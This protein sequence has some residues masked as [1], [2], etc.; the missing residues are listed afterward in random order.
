MDSDG[1]GADFMLGFMA[2]WLGLIQGGQ[3]GI[4]LGLPGRGLVD[5]GQE[6]GRQG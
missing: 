3:I 6:G 5:D 2:Q 1:L 4:R